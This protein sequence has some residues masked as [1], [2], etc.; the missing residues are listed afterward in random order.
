MSPTCEASA[1]SLSPT[2]PPYAADI[3]THLYYEHHFHISAPPIQSI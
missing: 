1:A 2:D 3:I